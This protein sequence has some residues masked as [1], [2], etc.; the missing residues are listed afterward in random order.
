M[1]WRGK[2]EAQHSQ[3]GWILSLNLEK[4]GE[5]R[6]WCHGGLRKVER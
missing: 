6:V 3:E 2:V 4:E 1:G 5:P